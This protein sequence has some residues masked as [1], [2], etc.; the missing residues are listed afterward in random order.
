MTDGI[1]MVERVCVAGGVRKL[2]RMV[3]A[4]YD[5]ALAGAGLK[6]SQFSVLV[7]VANR[8][9][10]R[11]AEL[12]KLLQMDES[13]LSRNVERMCARG[14]LRLE[15]N[16]DRRSHL[17]EVTDKGRALIRKCMPAWQQA[18]EEVSQ[19]IGADTVAALRSALR[20]LSA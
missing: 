1:K 15:R 4:I 11:P 7:A 3:S 17:I 8:D 2:N 6:T 14:W 9:K 10:A 5:S 19:R 20:K 16:E 18:Q 13:T 12:I